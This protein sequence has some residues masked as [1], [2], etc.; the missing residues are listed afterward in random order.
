MITVILP[1][2]NDSELLPKTISSCLGQP[3]IRE[4]IVIN[5]ASTKEICRNTMEYIRMNNMCILIN[6]E[7][8]YGLAGARNNAI[9]HAK[10][11]WILPIDCGDT[12]Y[13]SG[14]GKLLEAAEKDCF[15]S[16]VY[17][18]NITDRYDTSHSKHHIAKPNK[19][20]T[21]ESFLKDNPL[22]CSSLFSKEIWKKAGG[23][24]MR[25]HSFYEDYD[26]WCKCFSVGAKF[27]YVDT[28]VYHHSYN[29]NSMLS[30]LHSHTN[31]YKEMSRIGLEYATNKNCYKP[32]W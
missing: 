19:N 25:P 10:Y 12:I 22:F 8:N 13:P 3:C 11:D 28:L 2:Y 15:L 30:E 20:I 17:Y 27:K 24:T 29:E 7:I 14:A 21:K 23:Y 1:T 26:W 9:H 32:K 31:E 4:I 16:D 6:N 18:G 5:D